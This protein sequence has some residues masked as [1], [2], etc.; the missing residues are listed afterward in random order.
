MKLLLVNIMIPYVNLFNVSQGYVR[1]FRNSLIALRVFT[2]IW[3]REWSNRKIFGT[4]ENLVRRSTRESSGADLQRFAS[5]TR[6]IYITFWPG[7][8]VKLL[9]YKIYTLTFT[10]L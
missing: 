10:K 2:S 7:S 9:I 4:T 1:N 8:S 5:S 6:F 3:Q